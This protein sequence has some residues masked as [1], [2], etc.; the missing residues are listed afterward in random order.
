MPVIP[1]RISDNH[2]NI[3]GWNHLVMAAVAGAAIA[4][5]QCVICCRTAANLS[6]TLTHLSLEAD[7][8]LA[9]RVGVRYFFHIVDRYGLFP[10]RTGF[11]HA[12]Q[13]S[14]VRHARNIAAELAK[15]GEL[16]RSSVVFVSRN[17][18]AGPSSH[19]DP[20]AVAYRLSR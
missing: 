15:A 18:L 1:R 7:Y 2:P 5:D 16:F 13:G 12:D 20:R 11:E 10:D 3:G 9:Y 19:R 4:R 6:M 8:G 17:G 14:A